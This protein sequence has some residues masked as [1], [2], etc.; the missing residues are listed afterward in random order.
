[1][2]RAGLLP[3]LTLRVLEQSVAFLAQLRADGQ[4]MQV[5]VN[6]SAPDLLD[7]EF[8][9]TVARLLARYGVPPRQLRLE[10]TETV[11]MSDP[12][13][14]ISTLVGLR[15]QGVGLSLDDYGTG[16]SSLGYLRVLPVDELKID[17]SFVRDL[18]TDSACA[19]IVSSTI[20]LA[21]D[22]Q[23]HVVAEGV[24]DQL[25]LEALATA[26]CDAVQGWHTGRPA[27]AE[28]ARSALAAAAARAVVPAQPDVQRE[29]ATAAARRT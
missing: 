13:A 4:T 7:S 10:V 11:V 16:L 27:T 28:A 17:R 14:I 24:E 26:G 21:H 3:A 5:A 15:E 22:L 12:E 25:T 18:L 23:L 20:G 9:Q 29:P 1:V 2:E 8:P 6:L 19:L